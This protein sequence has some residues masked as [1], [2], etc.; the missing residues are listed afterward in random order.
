MLGAA[1]WSYVIFEQAQLPLLLRMGLHTCSNQIYL[2][3]DSYDWHNEIIP[4]SLRTPLSPLSFS[5][6]HVKLAEYISFCTLPHIL[7]N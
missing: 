5:P 2:A 7:L 1:K 6:R 4:M 3:S